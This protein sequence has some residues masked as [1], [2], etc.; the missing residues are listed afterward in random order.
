[1]FSLHCLIDLSY[2]C[3]RF[4][5]FDDIEFIISQHFPDLNHV[6]F[7][8]DKWFLIFGPDRSQRRVLI[9]QKPPNFSVF[10]EIGLCVFCV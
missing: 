1:M 7:F 10:F 5:S 4:L 2:Q 3:L 6:D 9:E 8:F